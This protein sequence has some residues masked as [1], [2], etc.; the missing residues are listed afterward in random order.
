MQPISPHLLDQ[1]RAGDSDALDALFGELIDPAF[2][3]AMALL[4]DRQAAED[5]VQEAA[6]GAW[7]KLARLRSG[8]E[9]RPW[10]LAF[11]ANQ[12]RNT[13]RARW[14]SILKLDT[15]DHAPDHAA[16]G[17]EDHVVLSADLRRALAGLS[18][19]HRVAI[20]LH[21]GLD[22]PLGEVAAATGVPL[23][24]VKSR[25]HRAAAILRSR[26]ELEEVVS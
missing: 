5:A 19:E 2:R 12:C 18:H 24:T 16:M 9:V 3:L 26:L 11:V 14:W 17:I 15:L 22:L 7:R 25:L 20:V 21:Y 4:H 23:G 8:A 6:V 10:F 13:R 1:A